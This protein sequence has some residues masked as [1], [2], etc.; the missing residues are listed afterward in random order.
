MTPQ[1]TLSPR[2]WLE[3]I[4]LGLI[5]GASFLAIRI[6]LDEVTFLWTVVHRVGWAALILWAVVRWKGIPLPR[7]SG[8]WGAFL[9]MGCLNNVI[10]FSLMAWGQLHIESGLTSILNASTAVFGVIVAAIVFP[11]ERLTLRRGAGVMIGFFGVAT[12]IGLG[13]LLDLDLRSLA[14]LAVLGGAV[15]YAFASAWA[16]STLSG[17]PPTLAAAGMLTGSTL[18]MLPLAW[19]VEGPPDLTLEPRTILAIAYYSVMA[20]AVAYLLFYRVLAMA[21]AGNL[22]LSTLIIPPIAIVLGAI[23]LGEALEI[24][25]LL[26]LVIL[27]LGLL[28]LDGRILRLGNK[29]TNKTG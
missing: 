2:A 22:M 25:A 27:V 15:S 23:F 16:R 13:A 7:S 1:K 9:I 5:W 26:G 20:T 6:A 28:I 11:D 29:G 14:Q 19:T 21:G 4:T 18:I 8:I 24:R 3:L 12:A 10:P 17:L